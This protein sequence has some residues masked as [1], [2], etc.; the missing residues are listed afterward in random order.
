[1]KHCV[2]Y[3]KRAGSPERLASE[4]LRHDLEQVLGSPV[5][6]QSEEA[7]IPDTGTVYVVGTPQSS[8]RIATLAASGRL[9]VTAES[10]GP[11]AGQII[12]IDRPGKGPLV[13]LAGCDFRGAQRAV[14]E[15]SHTCLGVDPFKYFTSC[16]PKRQPDFEPPAINRVLP[17]PAAPI[18]CYF[19]NDDDELANM[20]RPYL[21]FDLDTWRG[22]IDSLVRIGYN[23]ID[24][25]DQLGRSEFYRWEEYKKIRPD[26]HCNLGL[27]SQLIDYAHSKGMMIQ[28]PMYLA[29]EFKHITEE[30]AN[31]WTQHK[32]AWIDTWTYYVK[33]TPLGK[34]DI[35]LDRPRS[36]LWDS[37]YRSSTGED[38]GAVMTEAFTAL[39]DVV[40]GHN[41][42]AIMICDLYA[43]GQ[44]L[45]YEG[46]FQPP[47]DYIMAWPNDGWG[48]CKDFPS[49]KRGYA[50]GCYMH[51]GFWLNHVVQDPY[52]ERI[53][54]SMRE[55]LV[56]HGAN[57]Y[58]LVNGQTFR[59]FLLNLE[60]YSRAVADPAYFD[61][62]NF[63][64]EFTTRYFGPQ[65]SRAAIAALRLLHEVSGEG[66]VRLIHEVM[67]ELNACKERKVVESLPE[68][69]SARAACNERLATIEKALEAAQEAVDLAGDHADFCHDH[70]LLPI[71]LFAE[72]VAL[73][74]ALQD[75]RIG[76]N[77]Y[78]LNGVADGI[79]RANAA[80]LRAKES[81][82]MH[83]RTRAE[84]DKNPKW[85]TW[86]DPE[87]RRPNGGFPTHKDLDQVSFDPGAL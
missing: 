42:D 46:R 57:H 56:D 72:T 66:Y 23:A 67:D 68:L 38:I 77:E 70:L 51:A 15:F 17:Q 55:L 50:F 74:L 71:R 52:P 29:W 48:N 60:A 9:A 36:Q 84:G 69:R 11:Q 5:A 31:C 12:R 8:D 3:G 32:Q 34:A 59:H 86:Y 24:I 81:L 20:T 83:L 2:V 75:A 27:V 76:W 40:K 35:F 47:E 1:M 41:P 39:R 43:H 45:W 18:L 53:A 30:Q 87:K 19:D 33:E 21:E 62:N 49:D 14:Y 64:R 10:P 6:L 73:R 85:K 61:G 79:A 16:A 78:E 28:I 44:K 80:I 25:H 63:Y 82:A 7:G 4:D 37:Q 58:V 54:E 13:V 65:A 22:I 26:Y